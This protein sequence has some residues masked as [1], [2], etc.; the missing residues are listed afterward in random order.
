MKFTELA[1]RSSEGHYNN[2]L[3]TIGLRIMDN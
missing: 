3:F 2:V 1:L